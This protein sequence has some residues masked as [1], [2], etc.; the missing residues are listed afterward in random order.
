LKLELREENGKV[1]IDMIKAYKPIELL[2]GSSNT[3]YNN[4]FNMSR[5]EL[6]KKYR[7]LKYDEDKEVKLILSLL[8]PHKKKN[9]TKSRIGSIYKEGLKNSDILINKVIEYQE[10]R[11]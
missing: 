1:Y 3:A 8:Y 9:L 2:L 4:L 11:L 10:K 5:S 6:H 7:Y